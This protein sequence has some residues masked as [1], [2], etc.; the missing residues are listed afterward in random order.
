MTLFTSIIIA[1]FSYLSSVFLTFSKF[2]NSRTG[3]YFY[4]FLPHK[5]A[6]NWW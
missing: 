3:F 1:P 5:C 2:F 6:C 4:L